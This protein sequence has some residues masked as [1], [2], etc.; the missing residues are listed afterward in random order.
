[1]RPAPLHDDAVRQRH[2]LDLIVGDEDHRGPEFGVQPGDLAA[3]LHPQGGIQIG[4]RLVKD[5][6]FRFAS[7]RA[8]DGH[9]L[10]VSAGHRLRPAR[11]HFGDLKQRCRIAHAPV[12]LGLRQVGVAQPA[13]HVVVNRHV[14][15][16]RAV[17]EHHRHAAFG[18]RAF[19]RILARD[20]N[21][22]VIHILQPGD[23]G[24]QG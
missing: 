13:G 23:H 1:M 16:K 21:A 8:S 24:Q 12:D 4:K 18:G 6:D 5:E 14:G 10:P 15:I 20:Q 9:P 11:Q 7:N 22:A 2:R 17:L 3:H 19:G